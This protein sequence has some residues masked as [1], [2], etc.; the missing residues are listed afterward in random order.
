MNRLRYLPNDILNI[1]FQNLSYEDYCKF[2]CSSKNIYVASLNISYKLDLKVYNMEFVQ[3][4]FKPLK[5]FQNIPNFYFN[6]E[7]RFLN[8]VYSDYTNFEINP[9]FENSLKY[10]ESFIFDSLLKYENNS[11]N[12]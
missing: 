7:V 3:N 11:I 5:S 8:D 4:R 1:I 2:I 10:I 12:T 6:E 9:Y